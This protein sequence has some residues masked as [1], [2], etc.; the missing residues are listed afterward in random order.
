MK[1]RFSYTTK[2]FKIKNSKIRQHL[3][4]IDLV[5]YVNHPHSSFFFHRNYRVVLAFCFSK[6]SI[7]AV[8]G[9]LMSSTQFLATQS[10]RVPC[11]HGMPVVEAPIDFKTMSMSLRVDDDLTLAVKCIVPIVTKQLHQKLQHQFPFTFFL[12]SHLVIPLALTFKYLF[13][14]LIYCQHYIVKAC[15]K[16]CSNPTCTLAAL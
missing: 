6:N 4:T 1:K 13:I 3:N 16:K 5:S 7:A 10:K 11:G 15:L 14:R 9:C 8:A 2:P 12:S